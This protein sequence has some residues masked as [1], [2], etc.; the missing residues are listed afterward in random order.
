M[1]DVRE[2]P[3]VGETEGGDAR[4]HE[5]CMRKCRRAD[6]RARGVDVVSTSGA[7][8]DRRKHAAPSRRMD[9]RVRDLYKRILV[10]GRDYPAG[11]D[12]VRERAKAEFGKRAALTDDVEIKRAIAYG[13]YM[14][15]EMIGVVQLKKY[16]TMK[17]RYVPDD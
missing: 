17:K 7:S 4:E 12:H 14:V 10:V 5:P 15:K 3:Q 2:D 1:G 9:P 13:R 16:R 11:L 8:C 6:V